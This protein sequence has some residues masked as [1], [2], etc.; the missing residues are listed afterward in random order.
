MQKINEQLNRLPG[1]VLER[2]RFI[3][4]VA[5]ELN[6]PAYVVGGFV[7]D[8][9]LGVDNFDLDIVIEGSGIKFAE[10]LS[11]RLSAHLTRHRMFGTATV[12]TPDKIK[13]DIAT[14]RRETYEHPGSLPAVTFGTIRDDLSRRDFS[15][16]AMAFSISKGNF[17]KLIDFFQGRPDLKNKTLR[18]LHDLSFIDDPTRILRIIR[19]TERYN[20]K[21][22]PHTLRLIR[23][24]VESKGLDR[25]NKQRLRDELILLLKEDN[26]VKCIRR[27]DKL[28]GFS[29]LHPAIRLSAARFILFR[30]ID[31]TMKWFEAG[32][33]HKR[34]IDL[35]LIYLIILLEGLEMRQIQ[36]VIDNFAFSRGEKKRIISFKSEVDRAILRLKEKVSPSRIYRLLEPLSYEVILL[37]LVKE[38]DPI[39]RNNIR[40]FLRHYNE[41]RIFIGGAD[42]KKLGIKPGPHFKEILKQALYAKLDK[43]L[44]TKE[45][46]LLYLRKKIFNPLAR[47]PRARP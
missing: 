5:D 21:I 46:E 7:R 32:F 6:Y 40:D 39:V 25:I 17:G 41:T 1:E 26:P 27:L 9:L 34:K 47:I 2:L 44:K 14:A 4:N 18:I 29:F 37:I 19:F 22:S 45:E 31:R 36:E 24:A 3:G 38:A 12:V 42:L 28:C 10:E 11:R 33:P 16:N 30:R 43:Q 35:W 15:I 23:E 8:L 20:F 13:I